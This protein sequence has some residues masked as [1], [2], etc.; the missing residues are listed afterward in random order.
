MRYPL[1]QTARRNAFA[2]SIRMALALQRIL[3]CGG[4]WHI[5][6]DSAVRRAGWQHLGPLRALTGRGF[7]IQ[8]PG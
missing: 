2:S 3:F 6:K 4:I 8:Y 7:L 1:R 5:G